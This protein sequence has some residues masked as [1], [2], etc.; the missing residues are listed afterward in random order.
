MALP[1]R[2][3]SYDQNSD[4]LQTPKRRRA[5]EH[6]RTQKLKC[7]RDEANPTGSC[8]R[9]IDGRKDC[10]TDSRRRVGRPPRYL[11]D[12]PQPLLGISTAQINADMEGLSSDLP[13]D[14][15]GSSRID[16]WGLSD[17]SLDLLPMD[18]E[19][20]DT[21]PDPAS[22]SLPSFHSEDSTSFKQDGVIGSTMVTVVEDADRAGH[23]PGPESELQLLQLQQDLMNLV[24]RL[25]RRS[26]DIVAVL[27]TDLRGGASS[28]NDSEETLVAPE[29]VATSQTSSAEPS[30][31]NPLTATFELVANFDQLLRTKIHS[32][33]AQGTQSATQTV[34]TIS[35][36]ISSQYLLGVVACYMHILSA[37]DCIVSYV[38]DEFTRNSAVKELIL[39]GAPRLTIAGILAPPLTNT[40]G[41]LL[42]K[43]LE[44]KIMPVE[45]VLGLPDDVRVSRDSPGMQSN[46]AFSLLGGA[47]G[48]KSVVSILEDADF[49]GRTGDARSVGVRTLR[50]RM[51]LLCSLES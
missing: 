37:Y 29:S 22:H 19:G 9:C 41:R 46:R 20:L 44:E 31:F 14:L 34:T 28:N 11:V 39:F 49:G 50:T 42:V 38:L 51:Q 1:A 47:V 24:I 2:R 18:L 45:L 13:L 12:D 36:H 16:A 21:F 48:G 8:F 7:I 17:F 26:W 25:R 6:C 3:S 43:L 27:K 30:D 33:H 10:I 35:S 23:D 5:C 15:L 32:L 4:H 40:I